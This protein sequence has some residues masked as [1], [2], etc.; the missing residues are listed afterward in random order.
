MHDVRTLHSPVHMLNAY[1][2]RSSHCTRACTCRYAVSITSHSTH[3]YIHL[4]VCC[5][6]HLTLYAYILLQMCCFQTSRTLH[7]CRCGFF[8]TPH[9]LLTHTPVNVQFQS[10][11]TVHIHTYT[12]RYTVS[13][14]SARFFKLCIQCSHLGQIFFFLVVVV[15]MLGV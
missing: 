12:C 13:N 1:H 6:N 11:H 8:Q 3:V 9:T 15:V 10:P 4:Q 14:Q 2:S 5:F 7:I